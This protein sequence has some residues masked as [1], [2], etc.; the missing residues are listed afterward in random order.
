MVSRH[1]QQF[2]TMLNKQFLFIPGDF[3]LVRLYCRTVSGKHYI[4]IAHQKL[5]LSKEK[6]RNKC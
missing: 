3:P 6:H 5:F 1:A 2:Y 4:Q